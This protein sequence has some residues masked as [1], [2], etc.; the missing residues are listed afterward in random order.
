MLD[1]PPVSVTPFY[2]FGR[3]MGHDPSFGDIGGGGGV[4]L[5]FVFPLMVA[6]GGLSVSH[7]YLRTL[8]HLRILLVI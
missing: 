1:P 4:M 6:F 3:Y 7:G 2:P 8:K 5:T